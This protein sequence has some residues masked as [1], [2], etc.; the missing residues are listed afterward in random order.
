MTTATFAPV[1]LTDAEFVQIADGATYSKVS[2]QTGYAVYGFALA[3]AAA[4]P[5]VDTES[6]VILDRDG[7]SSMEFDLEADT[8]LYA[9]SLNGAAVLRGYTI[10]RAA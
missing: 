9:R 7:V 5:D 3:L 1:A 2:V 6:Y 8:I 10:T 4:K